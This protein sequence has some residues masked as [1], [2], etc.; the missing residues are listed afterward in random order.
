MT[1]G[2]T[3]SA[4]LKTILIFMVALAFVYLA[5]ALSHLTGLPVYMLEPMRLMVIIAMA[6]GSRNIALI[7]ASTLPLFSFLVSGHPELL[8]MVIISGELVLNVSLFFFL[9]H[10]YLRVFPA[11]LLSV[12]IS[13]LLCYLAYWPVFSF[14]FIVSEAEPLFLAV[15]I[16]TTL[17]FSFY[18]MIILKNKKP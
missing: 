4:L 15:Q 8:K 10:K 1:S 16:I 13:K 2:I 11:A 14:Q 18:L 9:K 7:L 6:H 5:P 3:F 17:I 12:A